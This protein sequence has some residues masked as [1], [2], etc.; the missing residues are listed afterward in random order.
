MALKK[1]KSLDLEVVIIETKEKLKGT[2]DFDSF[3][4]IYSGDT[5]NKMACCN[6][7]LMI[8]WFQCT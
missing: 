6:V 7:A 3:T 8:E 1:R 2:K 4:V 5:S